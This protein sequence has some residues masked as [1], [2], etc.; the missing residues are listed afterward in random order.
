MFMYECSI[1]RF[2]WLDYK[3]IIISEINE[4]NL[5]FVLVKIYLI[6]PN[7]LRRNGVNILVMYVW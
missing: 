2:F 1:S 5:F 7:L 6:K 4:L 3:E